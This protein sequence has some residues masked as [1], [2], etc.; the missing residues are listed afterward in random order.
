MRHSEMLVWL[1]FHLFDACQASIFMAIK[2]AKHEKLHYSFRTI[3]M[4]ALSY[5]Q[6]PN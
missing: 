2:L 3:N 6:G 5:R 4:K 1:H